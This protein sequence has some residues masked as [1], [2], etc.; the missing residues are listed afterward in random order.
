[1]EPF[2]SM[3]DHAVEP[4]DLWQRWL[5]ERFR[6]DGP[7]VHR[8]NGIDAWQI[9][10]HRVVVNGQIAAAGRLVKDL[11]EPTNYE[12]MRT[13]FYDPSARLADMDRDGVA[14]S[15]CF[16]SV[17]GFGGQRFFGIEDREL[18][19]ACVQAYNNWFVEE[20]AAAAP[21]RFI[22]LAT[23]PLWDPV[24]CAREVE[25]FAAMGG[26]AASFLDDPAMF[27]FPALSEG[28]EHWDPLFRACAETE[29]VLSVHMSEMAWADSLIQ[30]RP[31]PLAGSWR[32]W[33]NQCWAAS[34]WLA[35]IPLEDYPGLK[36]HLAEASAGW[37]P[38]LLDSISTKLAKKDGG[39]T[40]ER[41]PDM[42]ALRAKRAE[43]DEVLRARFRDHIFLS[44]MSDRYGCEQLEAV[45]ADNV[46]VGVDY[47]HDASYWPCTQD[48]LAYNLASLS[49]EQADKVLRGNARRVFRWDT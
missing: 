23:L 48:E 35:C 47:P 16:P 46:M 19:L 32:L 30:H 39:R 10:P 38:F 41:Y 31:G 1:M 40:P 17:G 7:Q 28:L 34:Q 27:G 24:A 15:L 20:W 11:K 49:D 9:G 25:R 13:E 43:W 18:A 42:T 14:V 44:I 2:Y 26:R 45:G 3:H 22:P 29:T 6:A 8:E 33:A 5:P 21:A 12:A 36:V 4:P 37:V